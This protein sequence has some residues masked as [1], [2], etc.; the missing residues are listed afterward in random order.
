MVKSVADAV[1]QLLDGE[2]RDQHAR[3]RN[4]RIQRS[5]R[6]AR[7]QAKTAKTPEVI[8]IAEPYQAGRDAENRDPDDDL[9]HEARRAVHRLG[10]RG[11][12]EM[13]V[14]ASSDGSADENGVDEK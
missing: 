3:Q 11:Q 14:A 9:D 12:I 6:R 10:N 1:D 7:R 5:D 4:D 13:I 8:E 2:Q